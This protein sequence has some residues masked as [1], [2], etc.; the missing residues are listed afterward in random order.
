MAVSESDDQIFEAAPSVQGGVVTDGYAIDTIEEVAAR[1]P[2][3]PMQEAVL[4]VYRRTAGAWVWSNG[5][6]FHPAART[7]LK[8][9]A[10]VESHGLRARPLQRSTVVRLAGALDWNLT[11]LRRAGQGDSARDALIKLR[12]LL[13]D[14]IDVRLTAASLL[15]ARQLGATTAGGEELGADL[16]E[17]EDLQTWVEALV[18]WHP[19]YQR[20]V[21]VMPTW[22][23][24]AR[25]TWPRINLPE[26]LR[27]MGRGGRGGQVVVLRARLAVEG[28]ATGD[29]PEKPRYFDA[30]LRDD[31]KRWQYSR[32]LRPNGLLDHRTAAALNVKPAELLERLR[33][34]MKTWRRTPSRWDRTYVMVNLPEYTVELY[35]DGQ[36]TLR[37]RAVVGYAF[38]TSGGRTKL[39][40]AEIE[41]VSLN[42]GWTP[43]DEML[44]G[45]LRTRERED[46]GYLARQG[47]SW[48]KRPDGRRGVYQQPGRRNVLGRIAL[49]F[50]NDNNIFLHG[51]PDKEQYR[52]AIRAQ[53][54]GCVRVEKVAELSRRILL[55]DGTITEDEFEASL[56][57]ERTKDIDLDTPIPIHIEY[58]LV[59]V[60]DD[61]TVRFLPNVYKM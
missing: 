13:F 36:R 2:L 20:L 49:R 15:L 51:S 32:G 50:P 25:Q 33:R 23:K 4:A 27:H 22:R 7:L 9:L 43:S 12:A 60:N 35:Q 52:E 42:P 39:F 30:Q 37:S 59:V 14:D 61:G 19:Q 29:P 40:H 56:S 1:V 54:H 24:Y 10:E 53:S 28:Y 3:E 55:Q 41:R 34:A 38:A 5:R 17:S 58:T 16:P 48:F 21:S 6:T 18:P 45:F 44:N 11:L 26:D 57:S 46:P 8:L 31:L 47:F